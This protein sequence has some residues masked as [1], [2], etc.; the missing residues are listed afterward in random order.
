MEANTWAQIFGS[1]YTTKEGRSS[2]NGVDIMENMISIHAAAG[3]Y[4][5]A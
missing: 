1:G 3:G 5:K 2:C 4:P